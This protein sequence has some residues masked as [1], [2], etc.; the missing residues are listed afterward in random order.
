[1]RRH[2]L[3]EEQFEQIKDLLPSGEGKQGRPWEDHHRILNGMF[4]ILNTGAQ[5]R[6]PKYGRPMARL[7]GTLWPLANRPLALSA[8]AR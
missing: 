5:I 7:A 3:S 8:L 2:E 6:A 4:W 1:M